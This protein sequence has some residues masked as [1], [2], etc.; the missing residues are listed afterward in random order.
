MISIIDRTDPG[1][2]T[3]TRVFMQERSP[4]LTV[5]LDACAI[6]E[7]NFSFKAGS[8]ARLKELVLEGDIK[9]LIPDIC[10]REIIAKI[11]QEE[12]TTAAA[13]EKFKKSTRLLGHHP[14]IKVKSAWS[15]VSDGK[16]SLASAA[17]KNGLTAFGKLPNVEIVPTDPA[18]IASVLDL[19]F[20]NAPPFS[21]G[22]CEFPDALWLCSI[23]TWMNRTK[24]RSIVVASNDSEVVKFCSSRAGWE[25]VAGVDAVLEKLLTVRDQ[26]IQYFR[27][28]IIKSLPALEHSLLSQVPVFEFEVVDGDGRSLN[29]EVKDIRYERVAI[30]P[31]TLRVIGTDS[32]QLVVSCYT[33]IHV[34]GLATFEFDRTFPG[35]DTATIRVVDEPLTDQVYVALDFAISKESVGTESAALSRILYN[36]GYRQAEFYIADLEH[37]G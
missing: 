3:A 21:N 19:Y 11:D 33:W 9:I 35:D 7:K 29:G 1:C 24:I 31:E 17:L 25:S 36:Q 14:D 30:V 28:L 18:A 5:C 32:G 6:I 8:L 26:D 4:P 16:P 20:A 22:K 10:Y 27:A 13:I 2:P 37:F 12:L 34:A 15:T 23:Q